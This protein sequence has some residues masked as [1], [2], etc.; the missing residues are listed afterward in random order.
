[1]TRPTLLAL[2]VASLFAVALPA[3]ARAACTRTE[4]QTTVDAYLAAQKSGNPASL[5]LASSAKYIENTAATPPARGI[6][7]T[8]LKIDFSRSL[9]DT[10]ICETFTEVIVT[11]KFH[12]YV[13]GV[14]GKVANGRLTELETLV[15]DADDWLFNADNYLKYSSSE[16]W[17]RIP[18][19]ARATR[20]ALIAAANAYFDV[21]ND[22]SVKVPWGTP[23]N[24][25]EG[26]V[27]TG[28]GLPSD[29][30]NVGVP[31]NGGMKLTDRRFI[32]D[33][34]IGAVVGFIR[35]PTTVPDSHVFRI[36]NGRIRFVHSLTVCTVPNC[37]FPKLAPAGAAPPP[38]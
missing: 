2:T 18:A 10:A 13:L 30:C 8:P 20:A 9:L 34:E 35:W 22:S 16:D 29:S 25:L 14:R 27:R 17:G 24:R 3:P 4:L 12:P 21:F 31:A 37:G 28:K 26:G 7:A 15:T 32:A 38:Q 36:E 19:G 11:D 23:C 6:L 1:M 5:P 33:P